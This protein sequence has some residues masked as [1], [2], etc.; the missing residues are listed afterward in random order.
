MKPTLEELER[1]LNDYIYIA[2]TYEIENKMGLYNKFKYEIDYIK[3][4]IRKHYPEYDK[5]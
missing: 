4:V 1:L 5:N 3:S 2:E